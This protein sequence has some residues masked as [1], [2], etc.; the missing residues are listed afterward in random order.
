LTAHEDRIRAG[1]P[2]YEIGDEVGRGGCGVVLLGTHKQ[3]HRRVAIKQIPPQFA[4]DVDVKQRFSAEARLMAEIDH[5]HVVRVYDYVQ[6]GDLCLLVMEYLS[7][8]TVAGRFTTKGFDAASAIAVALSCAAGLHD[9]HSHGVLHRDIKPANLMFAGNGTVKLTD[10]GIAKILR[11]DDVL[12]TKTGQVVGTPAYIAPEQARGQELSPAT[13]I[14]ALATMVYQLLSGRLPFPTTDDSMALLFMHAFEKPTPLSQVAPDI[15]RPIADVV[16]RGLAT[17]P[18]KRINSAETFGVELAANAAGSWGADWLVRAG[19]PV[20]GADTIRAAATGSSS[21]TGLSAVAPSQQV[22]DTLMDGLDN[23]G[24]GK[25]THGGATLGSARFDSAG[26]ASGGLGQTGFGNSGPAS[27]MAPK[28][29]LIRPAEPLPRTKVELADLN[30]SDVVPVRE[31]VKFPSPWIPFAF[32]ALLA[33]LA[34]VAAV[35]GLATP[36]RGGDLTPGMLTVADADPTAGDVKGVDL[37]KPIPVSLIGA[38][39]DQVALAWNVL[40]FPLGRH[41]SAVTRDAHGATAALPSPLNPYVIAGQ[42]TAEL[43][44]LNGADVTATYR[45]GMRS[46]Q[47]ATT[48]ALAAGAVLLALFALSYLEATMR[49][50]RQ[51]RSRVMGIIRM[52][53]SA[54]AL[55]VAV[56][57]GV[58]VVS[59]REATLTTLAGSAAL[60]ALAGIAA[61]IG[62]LRIGRSYRYRRSRRTLERAIAMQRYGTQRQSV[63]GR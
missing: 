36:P 55:A 8:G 61:A 42:M 4:K 51:A 16:M 24:V 6:D 31:V 22:S 29:T 2:G 39:G 33:A 20:Q 17:D 28:T 59:S 37:A 18:T 40:G 21:R 46:T 41:V 48:T 43:T 26:F 9:V 45:F 58:W 5:P 47:P 30:M 63:T 25:A 53:L 57:A 10:F 3:L 34:V 52:P 13:D 27:T 54:A 1:L 11:G 49:A 7:G 12:M 14:Y 23:T 50:M 32:A 44:V 19:I 38:T 62:A 15:P 35:V 60:A 56:V